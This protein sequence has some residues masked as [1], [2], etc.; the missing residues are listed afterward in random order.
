MEFLASK[1]WETLAETCPESQYEESEAVVRAAAA[2]GN[3]LAM[4]AAAVVA[5][6]EVVTLE[7]DMCDVHERYGARLALAAAV[8][9]CA[10]LPNAAMA[11]LT[12]RSSSMIS[13][14]REASVA[15]RSIDLPTA[16]APDSIALPAC[17][18]PFS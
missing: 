6:V 14:R 4:A 5:A 10:H 1:V 17:L 11:S 3:A 15:P 16:V 18:R 7:F 9:C 13:A 12:L 2:E 8:R